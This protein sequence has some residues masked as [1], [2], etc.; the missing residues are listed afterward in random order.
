MVASSL[1]SQNKVVDVAVSVAYSFHFSYLKM[2]FFFT[3][4]SKSAHTWPI[5]LKKIE[6]DKDGNMLKEINRSHKMGSDILTDILLF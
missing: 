1:I 3:S 6:R 4:D 2:T 5:N